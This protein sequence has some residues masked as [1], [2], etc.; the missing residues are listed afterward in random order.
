MNIFPRLVRAGAGLASLATLS[1]ACIVL[2]SCAEADKLWKIDGMTPGEFL[3]DDKRRRAE[4]RPTLRLEKEQQ[5]AAGKA[6]TAGSNPSSGFRSCRT[7]EA[8][9]KADVDTAYIRAMRAFP[10]KTNEED[11]RYM[12]S[13]VRHNKTPS[14]I[15]DLADSVV[16][17]GS[18]ETPIVVRIDLRLS[19]HGLGSELWS[20]YCLTTEDSGNAELIEQKIRSLV[21]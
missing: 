8:K 6:S 11:S 18:R 13:D 2:P 15:Y 7:V 10:F 5:A 16:T 17:P 19:K 14:V 21:R 3:D 20:K 1:L 9:G 12:Y 4:A